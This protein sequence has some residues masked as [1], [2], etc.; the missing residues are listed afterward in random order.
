MS[1]FD[2]IVAG[3]GISG[4][5]FAHH[6]AAKGKTVLVLEKKSYAG[7]CL[8]TLRY[9]DFWLELGGHTV[10]NS[11]MSFI[12]SLRD[13]SCEDK[14]L[15]REKASFKMYNNGSIESLMKSLS[16]F[17]AAL[18]IPK[19]FFMKKSGK[20][21]REYYS[22]ILG[23]N[24][25]KNMF[26][27]MLQA[28]ISQ[29]ASDC[30]A[31]ML[32]KKRERDDTAPR[33]FTLKNGMASFIESVACEDNITLKTDSEAVDIIYTDGVYNVETVSGEK[34]SGRQYRYGL[35]SAHSRKTAR[36]VRTFRRF[37]PL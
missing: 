20:S 13:L 35:S 14:F 18:N 12:R 10:Y 23:K 11:Y 26:S 30:P 9:E 2:F 3:S 21:V 27:P 22:A 31:D 4:M 15:P 5:S 19:M 33:N 16:K 37:A 34:I 32:L 8:C 17:E 36:R 24:N 28:V 1:K 29:D 6:M 7:G 25:Y